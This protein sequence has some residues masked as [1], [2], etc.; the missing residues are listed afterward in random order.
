MEWMQQMNVILLDKTGTLTKG[1]PNVNA[2][3]SHSINEAAL[4]RISAAAEKHSEHPL[5]QAIVREAHRKGVQFPDA[6]SFSTSVGYG[7]LARVENQEIRIG[8]R[9]FMIQQDIV[10]ESDNERVLQLEKEGNTVLFIAINGKHVGMF[11]ISDPIKASSKKA[12]E[13]LKQAKKQVIMVTGDNS[14]TA[15]AIA[16][17]AGIYRVYA[18]MLPEDK[19]V[20]IKLLQS[21]GKKVAMVGDGINDAPALAAANL[22][23]AIG[24]GSDITKAAA[25]VNLLQSDLNS[26]MDAIEISKQTIRNIRQNLGFAFTYNIIA[27]PFAFMGWLEPWMAGTAMA[28]SSDTVVGNS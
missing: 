2:I 28:L 21:K 15:E 8:S 5:A 26:V 10:L 1:K 22:G 3:F 18:D 19:V 24:T 11:A 9:K 14:R 13:R 7:V 20:L 27:I 25:D 4:L 16:K 6:D 12:I 17:E 23:V